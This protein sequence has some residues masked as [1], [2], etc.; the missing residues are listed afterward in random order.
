MGSGV[1]R[2]YSNQE[3][4]CKKAQGMHPIYFTVEFLQVRLLGFCKIARSFCII[5][6]VFVLFLLLMKVYSIIQVDTN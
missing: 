4:S 1:S 5:F 3:T 6:I 2:V